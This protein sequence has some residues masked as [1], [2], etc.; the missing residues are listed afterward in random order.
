ME[1]VEDAEHA[2]GIVGTVDDAVAMVCEVP[3]QGDLRTVDGE[4]P[5]ALP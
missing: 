3:W 2:L 4:N 5:V 1:P